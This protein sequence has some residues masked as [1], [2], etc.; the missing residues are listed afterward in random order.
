MK[1]ETALALLEQTDAELIKAEAEATAELRHVQAALADH[2][3]ALVEFRRT[4][5]GLLA[6]NDARAFMANMDRLLFP[7]E[8]AINSASADAQRKQFFGFQSRRL[9]NDARE[10]YVRQHAEKLSEAIQ[11]V[12]TSRD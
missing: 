8:R 9:A 2:E 1:I 3:A 10:G 4:G 7:N 12:I 5:R 6:A 11:A